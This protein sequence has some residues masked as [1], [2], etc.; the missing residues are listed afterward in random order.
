MR[1][2]SPLQSAST[3]LGHACLPPMHNLGRDPAPAETVPSFTFVV[4]LPPLR[5]TSRAWSGLRRGARQNCFRFLTGLGWA[6]EPATAAARAIRAQSAITPMKTTCLQCW[7]ASLPIL[8]PA[9]GPAMKGCPAKLY[10]RED[11]QH[12]ERSLIVCW[13][14]RSSVRATSAP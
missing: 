5:H 9:G 4:S 13:K 2:K 8:S 12:Q 14:V 6:S 11:R 10:W 3:L 1:R 7:R